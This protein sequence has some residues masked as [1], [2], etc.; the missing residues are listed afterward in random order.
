MDPNLYAACQ[1]FIS[2]S[3]KWQHDAKALGC[4][5]IAIGQH[6]SQHGILHTKW[7]ATNA[8]MLIDTKGTNPIL[9]LQWTLVRSGIWWDGI[10]D[11]LDWNKKIKPTSTTSIDL[12]FYLSDVVVN[13]IRQTINLGISFH[14][15]WSSIQS[16]VAVWCLK[17]VPWPRNHEH[18]VVLAVLYLA[19]FWYVDLVPRLL[20]KSPPP[21]RDL[22][23]SEMRSQ[24]FRPNASAAQAATRSQK[25]LDQWWVTILRWQKA[26]MKKHLCL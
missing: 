5:T 9:P 14:L 17:P 10:L 19:F 25:R 13:I 21:R 6:F 12:W 2:L 7:V 18:K 16:P 26:N 1:L 8:G 22:N 24:R 4:S 20:P 3:L 23:F 11:S 15:L